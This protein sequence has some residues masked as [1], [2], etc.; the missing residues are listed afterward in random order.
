[1]ASP[2][3]EQGGESGDKRNTLVR[4]CISWYNKESIHGI[5][6]RLPER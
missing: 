1:V 6:V 5:I 3:Y 2:L 4:G